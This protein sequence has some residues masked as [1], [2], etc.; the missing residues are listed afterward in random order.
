MR[1]PPP[2]NSFSLLRQGLLNNNEVEDQ[3]GNSGVSE[4]LETHSQSGEQFLCV[5][6][7]EGLGKA[8]VIPRTAITGG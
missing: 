3:D 7:G 2:P 4:D 5:D 8:P 6:H 1:H